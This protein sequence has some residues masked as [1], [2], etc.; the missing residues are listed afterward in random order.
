MTLP[1]ERYRAIQH[2]RIFLHELLNSKITPRVPKE[3]RQQ[4]SYCLRHFP[5]TFDM[6]RVSEASPEVFSKNLEDVQ[7]MFMKYE[8][9][10][11]NEA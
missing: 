10:K 3:I 2:T 9:G 1:D 5:S 11:Q 7:R 8:Q 4:A 6:D